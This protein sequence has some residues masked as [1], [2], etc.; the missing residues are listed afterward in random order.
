MRGVAGGYED[1]IDSAARREKIAHRGFFVNVQGRRLDSIRQRCACRFQLLRRSSGNS[2]PGAFRD[3]GLGRGKSD[4]RT[5][6]Q[7]HYFRV[8][9]L[10]RS[11]LVGPLALK[12][13]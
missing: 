11:P 6:A 2:D 12:L 9:E 3:R 10:H 1:V 4:P 8:G 13:R 5:A 7:D